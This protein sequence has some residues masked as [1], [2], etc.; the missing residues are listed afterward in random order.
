MP[1]GAVPVAGQRAAPGVR[2]RGFPPPRRRARGA[3][4]GRWDQTR[5]E[6][7]AVRA[8]TVDSARHGVGLSLHHRIRSRSEYGAD[9][10]ESAPDP[11]AAPTGGACSREE[12]SP[13]LGG[14]GPWRAPPPTSQRSTKEAGKTETSTASG[15]L[16]PAA[17]VSVHCSEG[18]CRE[19]DCRWDPSGPAHRFGS[20]GPTTDRDAGCRARQA[21]GRLAPAEFTPTEFTPTEVTP[22]EV[23][24]QGPPGRPWRSCGGLRRGAQA[25]PR[26][27]AR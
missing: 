16:L 19:G 11:S 18:D 2:A 8:L 13:P 24:P 10:D 25:R 22:T 20:R 15:P 1:R 14:H 17:D 26:L 21:A 27:T 3:R 6:W 5:R 4:G 7:R 23:T 9:S 12:V